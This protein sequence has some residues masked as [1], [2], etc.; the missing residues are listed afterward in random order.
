[1]G[2]MSTTVSA[3]VIGPTR[4]APRMPEAW[5]RATLAG[6]EAAI[7]SWLLVVVPAVAAY[8][9]TA[10]APLLGEASWMDA[11]VVGTGVWL[12]GHGGTIVMTD[13]GV[14]S[15]APLGLTLV[16]LAL[17]YGAA[18]R[19][20][21]R[22]HVAGLFTL[23]GYLLTVLGISAVVPGPA[24]R[25]GIAVTVIVMAALALQLALWRSKVAP[26]TW[27]REAL[28]RVPGFVRSGARASTWAFL[29]LVLLATALAGVALVR[30][31]VTI[32][33]LQEALEPG[34]LGT[35]ALVLGQLAYLPTLI[36]WVLAWLL[37]PGFAVGTGTVFSPTEVVTGPLPAIPLLGA[38]PAPGSPGLGWW[39][40]AGIAVGAAIGAWLHRQRFEETWWRA[41]LSGVVAALVTA[42]V[43]A[44]L[45]EAAAGSIGPGRM[46]QVGASPPDVAGAVAWQVALGAVVVL[47][48]AHPQVHAGAVRAYRATAE[49]IRNFGA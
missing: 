40:L 43:A 47:L 41:A 23:V 10:A 26:P 46:S 32:L 1:M 36:V 44:V 45:T 12:L 13:A 22:S 4:R 19:A 9:A 7:L 3:R 2:A 5:L 49:R 42:V 48:A 16:S 20:R 18:R 34:R 14:V 21:L 27:W 15:L 28:V 30:G 31:V 29:A 25:L 37:G 33:D 8:V 39:V 6:V 11:A 17:I 24:G 38:L 35:V